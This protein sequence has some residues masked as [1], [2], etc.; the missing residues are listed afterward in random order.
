MSRNRRIPEERYQF[1]GPGRVYLE[2]IDPSRNRRRFYVIEVIQGLFDVS[3][4]RTWGRIG[5]RG[6]EMEHSYTDFDEALKEARTIHR[7]KIVKGYVESGLAGM[8]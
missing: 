3:V 8:Y 1:T 7:S 5:N 4:R 2:Q 6:R